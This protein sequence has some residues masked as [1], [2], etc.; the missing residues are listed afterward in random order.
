MDRRSWPWRKKNSEKITITSEPSDSSLAHSARHY[1]DQDNSKALAEHARKSEEAMMQCQESEEKVKSLN[2]KLSA[3]LADITTKDSLV[4]QHAKVAEEAVSGWEKAEAE[5]MASKQQLEYLTQQKLALEDRVLHLDGAL[6]ECMRQ[7]R[8]VREEQEQKIHEAVLNKTREW[9]RIRSE[10]E[11]KTVLLE[12]HLLQAEAENTAITRSLQERLQT[13]SEL[14]EARAEAESEVKVLQVN[15]ESYESDNSALKYEL[16]VLSKELEIR[17]E[18]RNMSMKSAEA[19]TKQHLES[20]KKIAKLEAECQRLRGLVRKKLP[21]PAALA[22]MKMEVETL[23]KELG[24]GRRRRSLGK[25]PGSFVSSSIEYGHDNVQE[26]GHKESEYLTERML[27]MEEETKMLK[28]ALSKRNGELQ[29]SRILCART[30]SKLSSVEKQLEALNSGQKLKKAALELHLEGPRSQST[31]NP[32]SLASMSED[33]NDDEASCAE[34]WASALISE[35]SQF[36]KEKCTR[37]SDKALESHNVDLMNDFTEMERLASLP[38]SKMGHTTEKFDDLTENNIGGREDKASLEETLTKRDLE[39]QAA[40]QLSS[41]L[42]KKLASVQEQLTALQ[43]KNDANQTA[44]VSLQARLDIIFEVQAEGGNL[45]KVLEDV[46]CAMAEAGGA[47]ASS[48]SCDRQLPEHPLCVDLGTKRSSVREEDISLPHTKPIIDVT[49]PELASAI[50]RVVSLVEFIAEEAR[51]AQKFH[52]SKGHESEISVENF[53]ESVHQFL[54]GKASIVALVTELSSVL[55]QLSEVCA[56]AFG[57]HSIQDAANRFGSTTPDMNKSSFFENGN[58]NNSSSKEKTLSSIRILNAEGQLSV[59]QEEKAALESELKAGMSRCAVLQEEVSQLKIEKV[60][61][62]NELAAVKEKLERTKD[63]LTET[64]QTLANLRVQLASTQESKQLAENQLEIMASSKTQLESHL[65]ATEVEMNHLCEKVEVLESELQEEC[66]R[67]AD[68]EAKC[69]DLQEQLQR[70]DE[71]LTCSQCSVPNKDSKSRQERE[72]AA[73]AEKLAECQHTILVLGRQLKA[74]SSPK[75]F[76]DFSYEVENMDASMGES[77]TVDQEIFS[78]RESCD[79]KHSRYHPE[80]GS[81]SICQSSERDRKFEQGA[82]WSPNSRSASGASEPENPGTANSRQKTSQWTS[83]SSGM[84]TADLDKHNEPGSPILADCNEG[85]LAMLSSPDTE[86]SSPAKSPVKSIHRRNRV[87]RSLAG[88]ALSKSLNAAEGKSSSSV[89]ASEKH[90]S[91][92]S[93]F[94]ARTRSSH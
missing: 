70:K 14:S 69:K 16:H 53:S 24:E 60:E 93:R 47:L 40:N 18:E 20:V 81:N 52:A 15:I 19:A 56:H 57:E 50:S 92:F 8:H 71:D 68:T 31:S 6:K 63:Q 27:A 21:G 54:D 22:Q 25:G 94:F 23:G 88:N 51:N 2:E 4:K 10:F 12:Q 33:G 45:Q 86:A 82:P 34:S 77:S 41:D 62:E 35:L 17:N 29:A 39:L 79:P 80:D 7:L 61:L 36:R 64:E 91:G 66:R 13:I 58:L 73:A 11:A 78:K 5:A 26:Q 46:K 90:G 89:T 9:D 59:I 76:M 84:T 87:S 75:D 3:A 44:L 74:L 32:P 67:Y 42:S 83:V 38:S 30:A 49:N 48:H 43:S 37:K 65:K 72:I 1:D 85:H 55:V 28:E